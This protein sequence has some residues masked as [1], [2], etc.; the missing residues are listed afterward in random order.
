MAER[1]SCCTLPGSYCARVDALFNHDGVH[2]IDVGW[3]RRGEV[4]RLAL[5]VETH[6]LLV[7]CP[8]CGVVAAGHGRRVRRLHDI[9]AFGAP[10][11]LAWLARRY[12]CAEPLCPSGSF[13]EASDLAPPGALLTTR[14]V[15][16]AIGCLQR[17]TA[18]V[19]ASRVGWRWTGTPCGTP[20]SHC[21]SSSR[22]TRRGTRVWRCSGSTN[23][24][25]TTRL[26][27]ARDPR[28]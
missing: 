26:G 13:T 16:W 24:S 8:G 4:D 2:V 25:G 23:T 20:S 10:V 15:W 12:R 1:T 19:A 22:T 5:T 18:S 27:P 28:S 7:A 9:P 21:W 6:P 3:R 11:E 14:A 17:D